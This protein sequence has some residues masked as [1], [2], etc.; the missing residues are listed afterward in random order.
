MKLTEGDLIAWQT[1]AILMRDLAPEEL[2]LLPDIVETILSAPASIGSVPAAFDFN[3]DVIQSTAVAIFSVVAA[4]VHYVAPK[5]FEASIDVGKDT[6]KGYLSKKLLTNNSD[7]LIVD[8]AKIREIIG[9]VSAER[10][11][12]NST[13]NAIANAV[14]SRFTEK[15][16]K[17]E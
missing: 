1:T 4:C 3:P 7:M 11:L 8:I 9:Q 6:L 17:R 13:A 16:E 10:R 15:R 5:F 12:S 2:E 14:I